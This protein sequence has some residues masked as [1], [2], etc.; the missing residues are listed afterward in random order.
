MLLC[1]EGGDA[2][3]VQVICAPASPHCPALH[4]AHRPTSANVFWR[5]QHTSPTS[6]SAPAFDGVVSRVQR[7]TA[8]C[9]FAPRINHTHDQ[10]L[11][12]WSAGAAVFQRLY[13][14]AQCRQEEQQR[15]S[16]EKARDDGDFHGHFRRYDVPH[17]LFSAPPTTKS[18]DCACR[19]T[20][21]GMCYRRSLTTSQGRPEKPCFL[22]EGA[23]TA[24]AEPERRST[25]PCCIRGSVHIK[26]AVLTAHASSPSEH[27]R[28]EELPPPAAPENC[29]S[30]AAPFLSASAARK[31]ALLLQ[32]MRTARHRKG[33]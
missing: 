25:P 33:R 32:R 2:A 4:P 14:H 17:R 26:S 8:E 30:P 6:L 19:A 16:E 7:D 23:E 3:A 27:Q 21:H 13:G 15:Q 9:T 10:S 22:P 12:R 20:R 31:A 18:K 24:R 29:E 1:H 11:R 5:L 28:Q